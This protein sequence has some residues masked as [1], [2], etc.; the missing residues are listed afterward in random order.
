MFKNFSLLSFLL[1][2]SI[3]L[4]AQ[5]IPIPNGYKIL[6]S[7]KGDLDN[8]AKQELAVIY[9]TNEEDGVPG[10]IIIY[11]NK[12]GVWQKWLSS[13]QAIYGSIMSGMFGDPNTQVFIQNG[14]LKLEARGKET[15]GS[16]NIKDEY[17]LQG[18]N[19][20]LIRFESSFFN[21]CELDEKIE[22]DSKLGMLK[23]KVIYP[24]CEAEERDKAEVL[25]ESFFKSIPR[26]SLEGRREKEIIINSPKHNYE[27]ILSGGI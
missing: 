15:S 17:R 21:A 13:K 5:S 26:I 3:I 7:A 6:S 2:G 11:Q 22:Y 1:L 14:I 19:L 12:K 10:E 25:E 18:D 9:H 27:I 8:D 24:A 16:W 20:Y 4:S 23:L